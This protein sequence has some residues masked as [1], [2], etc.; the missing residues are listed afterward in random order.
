V[1]G[2]RNTKNGKIIILM[3]RAVDCLSGLYSQEETEETTKTLHYGCW[4]VS[5]D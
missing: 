5:R 3:K 2:R 1:D 4:E